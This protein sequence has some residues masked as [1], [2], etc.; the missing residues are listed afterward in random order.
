MKVKIILEF[1][2]GDLEDSINKFLKSHKRRIKRRV[3]NRL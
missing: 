3:P 1:N 2:P